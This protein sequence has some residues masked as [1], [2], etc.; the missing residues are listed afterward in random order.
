VSAR[1][2]VIVVTYNSAATI[3]GCLRAVESASKRLDLHILI[4]DNDSSDETLALVDSI[5]FSIPVR[6]LSGGGNRGYGAGNNIGLR[7]ASAEDSPF[8][9]VLVLNPDVVLTPDSIDEL[10][11]TLIAHPT[12]GAVS[13]RLSD[14]IPNLEERGTY[15][16]ALRSLWGWPMKRRFMGNDQ[17]VEVDRLPGSCLLIRP[18]ALAK[19]EGFDEAYFMYW[20]EIDLCRRLGKAGYQLL[21][22]N[23]VR[24]IHYGEAQ[25]YKYRP[26][27]IYY[28]W[29]NQFY[30]SFKNYGLLLG[31]LFLMRRS[32]SNAIELYKFIRLRRLDLCASAIAGMFAGIAGETYRSLSPKAK[33]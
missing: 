6:I 12:V 2:T 8:D 19:V 16:L 14:A 24:V 28:M 10:F 5:R 18:E 27:R 15:A 31:V 33:F 25:R 22:C 20:E 23:S 17:L 13:P 3:V 4:V 29:R 32:V 11:S 21:I 1:V 30:F 26:Q 9:A 7:A